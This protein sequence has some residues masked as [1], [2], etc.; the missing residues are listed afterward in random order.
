MSNDKEAKQRLLAEFEND[1]FLCRVGNAHIGIHWLD[2]EGSGYSGFQCVKQEDLHGRRYLVYLTNRDKIHIEILDTLFRRDIWKS[3]GITRGDR[4]KYRR[5]KLGVSFDA[6]RRFEIYQSF[7]VKI[8]WL[9]NLREGR[10]GD[11]S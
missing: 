4:L 9:S 11:L 6:Y 3:P 5:T 7:K 2:R 1:H 10:S 8:A